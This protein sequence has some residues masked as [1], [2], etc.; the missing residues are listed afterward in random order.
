MDAHDSQRWQS[1]EALYHAALERKPSARAAFLARACGN[2]PELRREVES[3]LA[4]SS[5]EGLLDGS[6]T[7]PPSRQRPDFLTAPRAIREGETVA[8]YRVTEKTGAGGMG[9]VYKAEDIRLG[10][11]VALKFLSEEMAGDSQALSRFLREARAASALNHPN[12]CTIHD[13]EEHAGLPVIVMEL[14][15]GESLKARI[16]GQRFTIREIED[17][18]L[19]AVNALEAA[20]E[21]GIIHRDIKSAN[22]FITARGQVK[23][24]DFGLAKIASADGDGPDGN[25]ED[26]TQLTAIGSRPGTLACMS[27]EQVTG[28]TL[29]TRTDLFSFGVVLYEMCTGEM[30]FRG[31][32]PG[33]LI[34]AILRGKPVPPSK[35]NPTV[36][37]ELE[38]IIGKCLEKDRTRRYQR[39]HDI[40]ADL[41][42]LKRSMAVAHVPARRM[43]PWKMAVPALAALALLVAVYF[44]LHRSPKLTDKDTIVLADFTNTTGEPVFDD[45]LRQG[46]AVQ[47]EQSPF[48]SLVPEPRTQHLLGVMGKPANVR[49]S[50][51]TADEVCVRAG[52]AA[53]IEGSIAKLGSQYILDL[54][55]KSC[56]GGAVLYEERARA[57]KPEEVLQA[58]DTLAPKLRL[59]LGE[60]LA[61]VQKHNTPLAEASTSS[62][63]A[64]KAYSEGMRVLY[65]S[66]DTASIV[67]FKRAVGIDP[68]FAIA[69][70]RL[71]FSYSTLGELERSSEGISTSWK[72]RDRASDAERYFIDSFYDV[73]V[74]GNLEKAQLLCEEWVRTYPREPEPHACLGA[75]VYPPQGK[76]EQA[77]AEA[78]N[79]VAINPS[80]VIGYLQV[81]FNS[82]FLG[83]L[84]Q[85]D[86]TFREAAKRNLEIPEFFVQRYENA[87]LRNDR[88]GIAREVTAS[89]G[90]AG[91]EE[92]VD[93]V[94]SM[95]LAFVG[96]LRK[97]RAQAL[98]S[99]EV[100]KQSSEKERAALWTSGTALWSGF[101]G[102]REGARDSANAALKL[103][104]GRDVEYAAALA[105][106]LAGDSASAR[107]LQKDLETHFPEDSAVRFQYLPVI[108][109]VA[110][111][112]DEHAPAKAIEILRGTGRYDE[113]APPSGAVGLF[114]NVYPPYIRGLA[115]LTLREG[116]EAVAEFRKVV[117]W[118][119]AVG[120]DPVGA[121]TLLQLGRALAMSGDAA[122][123]RK[124]Y[125]EFLALWKDADPALPIYQQAKAEYQR[126]K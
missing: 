45:T 107:R 68:G 102:D 119:G 70:A 104:N 100:A 90:K 23:V 77:L 47:L 44:Y 97:A 15:D 80:F 40:G 53:V 9:V 96:Q 66:G 74:L 21:K 105:L 81:A 125:E 69:H 51:K 26:T 49:L 39:A 114:G 57:G 86:A 29:D 5:S 22:I 25:G 67:Y 6:I 35:L 28:G 91:T 42:Q 121:L 10:R 16:R 88:E 55:A 4:T 7:A 98:R 84:D 101:F 83:R 41:E 54:R 126:M 31:E 113:G 60:S 120:N 8:H 124:S 94:D 46:L 38:R 71:G 33:V 32:S 64:L 92:W 78:E 75:L 2:D 99:A 116:P 93:Y 17:I 62:L 108:G 122:G 103:S 110:A 118:R 20:H 59:R 52:G 37:P 11:Q 14:L 50:A 115:L 106:A 72:L 27:P 48:L 56:G 3:L 18:A 12:I 87:F 85:S 61:T 117:K 43:A 95:T 24:L 1:I 19:Q 79:V 82:T 112:E 34:D 89:R 109:A 65:T 30:P 13:V 111:M 58:L 63:E 76:Y 36:P 123:A 73:N